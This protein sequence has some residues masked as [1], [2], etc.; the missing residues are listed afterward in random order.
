[1]ECIK[2]NKANGCCNNQYQNSKGRNPII[3]NLSVDED[4]EK[5]NIKNEGKLR[6][7]F[8]GEKTLKA[9]L[10]SNSYSENKVEEND[11]HYIKGNEIILNWEYFIFEEITKKNNNFIAKLIKEDY[12]TSDFYDIIII[13]VNKLLDEKSKLF[14]EDIQ[15]ISEQ[16]SNQPFIL[17]VT[18]EEDPDIKDLYKLITNEYFDKRGL[19]ATKF[20]SDNNKDGIKAILDYICKFRS[21][22]HEHG[23]SFDLD[24]DNITN[25]K[26]NILLCGR[27]GTG[28]SSFINQF[29]KNRRAKEGEGLS[30]THKIIEYTHQIYPINIYDTPGF[31]DKETVEDVISLLENLNK[32]LIDARKKINLILYFFPYSERSVLNIEVPLLSMLNK[33]NAKII[34]V[35]NFVTES[36]KSRH[37]KRIHDIFEESLQKIF[38]NNFEVLINPINLYQ[39]IDDDYD[40]P[41]IKK[42][43]GLD[44]LFKNIY[45]IYKPMKIEIELIKGIKD[46]SGLFEF[47]GKNPLYDHFKKVN[48]IFIS[49]R[50]D[51]INLILYYSRNIFNKDKIIKEMIDTLYKN[52]TGKPCEDHN[53]I[54]N[55]V[56][57]KEKQEKIIDEFFKCVDSLKSLK[58]HINDYRFFEFISDYKIIAIGYT[59][60]TD[61]EKLAQKNPNL[62]LDKSMVNLDLILNLC[63]SLNT[64]IDSFYSISKEFESQY[65]ENKTENIS[66][67]INTK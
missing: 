30:V 53:S 45:D 33:Y 9:I 22:Y 23:N 51:M 59:C 62:L 44:T 18:K 42:K 57:S 13:T 37:Y 8:Y 21:Y 67:E 60:L 7:Y 17:F 63:T 38:P 16:K 24:E 48:D 49:F 52:Y 3:K 27:A 32:K 5:L 29:L 14:F 11:I 36:I 31:E 50:S 43:F 26:F 10:A 12:Q 46:I 40:K 1:M 15:N 25:Y 65:Q 56:S 19:Y 39:Q 66:L 47:F 58:K 55:K 64:A 61:L 34:F 6:L 28:K 4:K 2:E 20:P 41:I 54:I 35:I